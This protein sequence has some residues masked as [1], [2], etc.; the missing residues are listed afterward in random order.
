MYSPQ[1]PRELVIYLAWCAGFLWLSFGF[2]LVIASL[3]LIP[4][5]ASAGEKFRSVAVCV[6]SLAAFAT[7]ALCGLNGLKEPAL[8]QHKIAVSFPAGASGAA[9]TSL[10]IIQLSDLHLSSMV[11]DQWFDAL[12]ETVNRARPDLIALTGDVAD[13]LVSERSKTVDRLKE[14]KSVYGTV[15]IPGNH[16]YYVE[17]H[18]WMDLYRSMGFYV[19]ENGAWSFRHGSVVVDVIGLADEQ[20]SSL[21]GKAPLPDM[22]AAVA[23]LD[24]GAAGHVRI[25]LKHRPKNASRF[26]G[27]KYRVD[28]MLCGHTHGGMVPPVMPLAAFA[29]SGYI[30][31][32]YDLGQASLY[33]S[34]GTFLWNGFPFRLFTE[35]TVAEFLLEI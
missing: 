19:L 3:H 5:I 8:V 20:A 23:G 32:A 31:G 10:K 28:L 26:A 14:L 15:M 12:V 13:G 35:N 34:D 2:A 1:L 33:V 11:S 30:R 7:V 17:Y 21:G 22:D 25:L 29:N 9:K 18:R 6:C 4:K 16:E 24:T 27:G